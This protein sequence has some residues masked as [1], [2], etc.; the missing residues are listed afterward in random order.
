VLRAEWRLPRQVTVSAAR[1]VDRGQLTARG[2]DRVLRTAWTLADLAGRESPDE[3]DVG[4]AL[5]LRRGQGT[6]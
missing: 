1:A 3:G 6:P 2:F 5:E 4:E